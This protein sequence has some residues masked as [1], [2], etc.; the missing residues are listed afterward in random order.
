MF[1]HAS[2]QL[3]DEP[4]GATIASETTPD[5]DHVTL[6]EP[7]GAP[8]RAAPAPTVM[9]P[10]E[11]RRARTRRMAHR[12]RLQ[13]YAAAAVLLLVYV[14]ALAT[15]NTGKVRIDWVFAHSSVPLI[16]VMLFATILG[17]LLGTLLTI[18]FRRRTRAAGRGP[19]SSATR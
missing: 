1:R 16:W 17:W 2:R 6:A 12:T 15:S 9:E 3:I 14:V 10:P 7:A 4:H 19:A 8:Q 5:D 11:T 13:L 18:L